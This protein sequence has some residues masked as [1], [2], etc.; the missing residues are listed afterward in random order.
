[1][2]RA[3]GRT[4]AVAVALLICAGASAHA[5]TDVQAP[6][7]SAAE[8]LLVESDTGATLYARNDDREV[9]IASVTKMMTAYV[10]LEHEP[11][12]RDLVEQPYDAGP[13]ESIAG[14]VGGHVAT[15]SGRC[16]RRCCCRAATT[17]P[18][19]LRSMSAAACRTSSPR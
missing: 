5:R 14:L 6:P 3:V 16:W 2:R 11:L 18:T 7:V 19:R 1:M 17:S 4:I 12:T 8:A 9:A 13:G 10:T 15:A